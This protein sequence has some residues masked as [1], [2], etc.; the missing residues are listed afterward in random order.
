MYV[1]TYVVL[2]GYHLRG[3]KPVCRGGAK[4]IDISALSPR[5]PPIPHGITAESG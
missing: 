4:G 1:L 3:Q 2:A 5:S